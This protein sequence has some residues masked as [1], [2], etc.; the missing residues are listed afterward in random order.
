MAQRARVLATERDDLSFSSGT[1][2]VSVFFW[3]C[4]LL[5]AKL[6]MNEAGE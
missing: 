4:S 5:K 6:R 1:L 3:L 2:I